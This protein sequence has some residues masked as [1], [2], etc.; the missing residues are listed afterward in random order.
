MGWNASRDHTATETL[1][2]IEL[3]RALGRDLSIV[4]RMLPASRMTRALAQSYA[5]L[6]AMIYRKPHDWRARLRSLFQEEIPQV[7]RELRGA[8]FLGRAAVRA[9]RRRRLVAGSTLSRA[10]RPARRARR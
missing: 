8:D 4:R 6:H 10:D 9:Q 2:A 5:R 3:Y 1:Q 7:V